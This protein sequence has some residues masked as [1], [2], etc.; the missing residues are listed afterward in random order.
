MLKYTLLIYIIAGYFISEIS[1]KLFDTLLPRNVFKK[2]KP[3]KKNEIKKGIDKDEKS[4]MKNVDSID[5]MFEP[6]VKRFVPSRTRKT[7]VVGG[8]SQ[9]IPDPGDV[10]KSKYEKA[11][12]FFENIKNEMINMSS[13]INKQLDSQDISSLNNFK[14]ASE[15]LK[16]SLATMH[17]LDIIRNDGSVDFSKYT[18]DWYSKANMREKYSIEKRKVYDGR[19]YVDELEILKGDGVKN[20]YMK[21]LN[22]DNERIYELQNNMRVS[23]FDYAI[24]NPDANIIVFDGNNYVSSYALR[25]MG[26]EHERIVWA[27]P[28][29]GWTAEFALSAISDNPLPIFDGSA[30]VLLEKLSI[31]SILGKHLPSDV[32]GNS[33]ANTVNFVILNKD[34]KPILKNTTLVKLLMYYYR[35]KI[36]NIET[37]ADVVLIMLLYLNSANELSEKGYLDV[38]SIS[39][40]DEF[41]LINKTIDRSHKFNKKIKIKKKTFFKIAPFNFF[42]EETQEKTG[43]ESIFAIDDIIKTSLLAKKSQNYNSLYETTKDLWNQ[44]QNMYSASYGFVQS[45]KIKTNKFVGSKIRNVGFL[46]RWFNYNK[47]PS[48]NINFLVNNFSPLVS[49]SLQLVF[50][51]TTMIE[52]YESSFLGNFSSAL[53]KIFTLGKSGRNPR[54]Y[55]DLVNFSE[56]DYLLR[57][58]KANNVQRIIM[59]IIRML[60]KKFLSSSYTPT[61]LA[62]YMSIFLSLWVFE[63]ENNISLQN[64]NISRFKKIFF[65]TYFVHAVINLKYATFTLSGIVNFV[66]K[67]E[68]GIGNEIIVH[69]RIP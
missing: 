50:F 35:D 55:N 54:N 10:E 53:K 8:L 22:E 21:G 24:Q 39:T 46:L 62:Q 37:S 33:L 7:H 29:V 63:G 19:K 26:L 41:N 42:R 52:Q 38:S 14:R 11:V 2:P 69:T 68:K 51:I 9:S 56:V 44:I 43:N 65:L 49:I 4:I 3:F 47:T 61:L 25:N 57:T 28:S 27:G 18:L 45:K 48:K 59:Q 5:V 58:S 32:N 40:D 67:A 6:R 34:G 31:R 15:V 36:Y 16:E 12:R 66:I 64:P 17:S 30:W 23:E 20:I 13:K 60:K 1:N